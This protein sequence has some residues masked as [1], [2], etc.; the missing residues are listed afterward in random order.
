MAMWMEQGGEEQER[1]LG[2]EQGPDPGWRVTTLTSMFSLYGIVTCRVLSKGIRVLVC[3]ISMA[4]PA[5]LSR[6]HRE[7]V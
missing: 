2:K 7:R 4:L 6:L 5:E 1:T 3:F